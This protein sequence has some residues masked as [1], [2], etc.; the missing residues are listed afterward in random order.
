MAIQVTVNGKAEEFGDDV[1]VKD[2]LE[3][4]NIRPEVVTVELN[5]ELLDREQFS[6]TRI[7]DGDVIEMVFY[8]GG[9]IL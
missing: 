6:S 7:K 3:T 1:T 4:K 8:I 5:E 9:G 2:I